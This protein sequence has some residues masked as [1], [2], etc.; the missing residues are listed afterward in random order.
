MSF[1]DFSTGGDGDINHL[2]IALKCV[3]TFAHIAVESA[4]RQQ[5]L[6]DVVVLVH[7]VQE[8]L[9]QALEVSLVSAHHVV[10][11]VLFVVVIRMT[12]GAVSAAVN[13]RLAVG[14][15][16]AVAAH[17][18]PIAVNRV[19][20]VGLDHVFLACTFARFACVETL[21]MTFVVVFIVCVAAVVVQRFGA[22][23]DGN[24]GFRLV[25]IF[26]FD[27]D[28]VVVEHVGGIAR[29]HH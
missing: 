21:K 17:Q 24:L 15:E 22:Q 20:V 11:V 9:V 25:V 27:V 18:V 5:I 26:V 16:V 12:V 2:S 28:N 1:E 7:L 4:P 29:W 8:L 13:A 10:L 19:V 6:V 14:A 3:E 23:V